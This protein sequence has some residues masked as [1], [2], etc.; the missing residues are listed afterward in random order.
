MGIFNVTASSRPFSWLRSLRALL[1]VALSCSVILAVTAAPANIAKGVAWL[2]TQIQSTGSLVADSPTA[3]PPQVQCETA[4]T[5]LQLVGNNAQLASL[6]GALQAADRNNAATESLA[7]I[8]LLKQRLGQV[9]DSADLAKRGAPKGGFAAYSGF[10]PGNALDTGWTLETALRNLPGTEQDLL[11]AW[12][13]SQQSSDGSFNLNGKAD[14]L[15]TAIVLRGLKEAASSKPI[16]AL[17]AKKAA[18]YLLAKRDAQSRWLGDV[19]ATAV[20]FEAVHPYSGSDGVVDNAVSA[21]LLGQ[22]QADGSWQADP[23]VT[24]VVLRALSLAGQPAL[25]PTLGGLTVQFIDARTASPVPGVIFTNVGAGT[26]SSQINTTSNANGQVELRGLTAGP[27]ALQATAAGYATV[28]WDVTLNPGQVLDMARVQMV[29]PS[30][31]ST[32]VLSGQVREQGTNRAIVGASITVEGQ[33]LSA[34][35]ANDGSYLINNIV[36]GIISVT[37]S[38]TGYLGVAGSSTAQEGRVINFSPLLNTDSITSTGNNTVA[39]CKIQGAILDAITLL[40]VAGVNVGA[41]GNNTVNT[42]T[43]ANGKYSL[44]GLISG[45]TTV[46]ASK[47]GY[48]GVSAST[49]LTCSATRSSTTDFSPKLYHS[50]TTPANENT[51]GL[52]GVIVNAGTNQVIAGALLVITP[53]MGGVRSLQTGVDGRFD[54][55]GLDGSTVQIQVHASGYQGSAMQYVLSPLQNFDIGQIRLRAPKVEQLLP[56]FKVLSIARTNA[57]SNP[58]TLQL[59]G[60][61]EVQVINAGNQTAP[62]NINVIAFSDIN[63]NNIFDAGVDIVLGQ[64]VIASALLPSQTETLQVG[65]NGLQAFR[66]APIHVAID[67]GNQIAE[68]SKI[69]NVRS[70]AQEASLVVSGQVAFSPALKW[71]WDGT[72]APYPDFNQ[73]MSSPVTGRLLDTNGDGVINALDIPVVVF[74]S[75]SGANYEGEGVIRIVRGDTGQLLTSIKD[76]AIIS[77]ATSIAIADLDG[78]GKPEIIAATVN[79]QII[80][81]SNNGIRSWVSSRVTLTQ[82]PDRRKHK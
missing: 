62:A 38:K 29:V 5:L 51:A 8:Q 36:P 77:G 33:G 59:T 32:A 53:E 56:D 20:V 34:T 49:R 26:N 4:V 27:Y 69:N 45:P 66:D 7:R 12:L 68:I 40:P 10:T 75:Y 39:E 13:Q 30:N 42:T 18:T 48:D 23:Y 41:S 50:T 3:T 54:V 25:D 43:D 37:A 46:L 19:A 82:T 22:Q 65:V 61:V 58:Q 70:T 79:N 74:V 64:S 55:Q 1:L 11:L 52:S 47:A 71:H 14:V 28:T 78:D 76:L 15:S 72:G 35:T 16:A 24:A 9:A 57:I 73:V 80:V 17:V 21:Y 6:M 44:S 63:Q 31:P 60:S 81:F 67:P 2:Q